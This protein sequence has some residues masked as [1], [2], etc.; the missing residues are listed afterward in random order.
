[1]VVSYTYDAWGKVLSCT[2]TLAST[3]GAINP[4]RYR[5]YYLD[6]ETGYYYL[7][8]RYYNPEFCRFINADEPAML[9]LS[10]GN[11][12]GAN[13]F[14][15]C[16]ND[17][18]NFVDPT[19]HIAANIVGAVIGGI[20]GVV[21]GAFLGNWLADILK[22]K[23]WK[24]TIF[25]GG[26]AVLVGASAAAIGYFIGPYV[27]KAWSVWSAKLAGLLKGTF[28][29]IAK[30]TVEKMKHIN[31]SKHLW[32]RVM[33][34]VTTTQIQTLI[35]QGIRKGTW[36]FLSNGS[37]KIV[38]KYSGEIIVITGKVVNMIFQIG[39]AWVWNGIGT[40]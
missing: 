21:G 17:P 23:G 35:H 38:Y 6:S 24:R 7:Q 37:V 10:A 8:S 31:V 20:L 26:V 15:Y 5:D 22:L 30:I 34:K 2:G 32:S 25:V 36:S 28:K 4:M 29:D 19:G 40:P 14:A 3:V 9:A 13:L 33:K 1:M 39:D 18:V 27:A 16:H 11:V 12:R